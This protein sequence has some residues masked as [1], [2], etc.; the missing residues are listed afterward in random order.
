LKRLVSL[1]KPHHRYFVD[2]IAMEQWQVGPVPEYVYSNSTH[3]PN[4]VH[5][6][7]SRRSRKKRWPISRQPEESV[8]ASRSSSTVVTSSLGSRRNRDNTAP[9]FPISPCCHTLFNQG[10]VRTLFFFVLSQSPASIDVPWHMRISFHF[11]VVLFAPLLH[12][13]PTRISQLSMLR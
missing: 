11:D 13:S 5:R 9:V 7:C 2:F 3:Q 6:R 12:S 10:T 4:D 1:P 8:C